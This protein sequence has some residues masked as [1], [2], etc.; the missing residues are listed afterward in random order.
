MRAVI[1]LCWMILGT[2]STIAQPSQTVF[3]ETVNATTVRFFFDENYFLVDKDC[4]F[5]SVERV[6]GFDVT[7]SQLDGRFTDFDQQGNVILEGNYRNGRKEGLFQAYHPNGVKKWETRFLNNLPVGLWEYYYPDG[8]PMLTL[9]VDSTQTQIL[10]Y[11][12]RRGR[13]RVKNGSGLYDFKIPMQG[14][15]PYG[16]SFLRYRG[17]LK[18]GKPNGYWE[19]F[20]QSEDQQSERVAEE[21]YKNGRLQ[22]GMDLIQQAPYRS[23]RYNFLPFESFVRG[24]TLI[25]KQCS[26]DD[27]SGFTLYLANHLTT[28]FAQATTPPANEQ[29]FELVFQVS[30]AGETSS[31]LTTKS[32]NEEMDQAILLVLQ[33]VDYFVP[34]VK[35]DVLIDDKITLSG[36]VSADERGQLEFHSLSIGRENGS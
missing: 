3:L 33:S 9:E 34:S 2:L 8:R 21:E 36:V 29:T 15:N 1:L 12:D 30:V 14:Y 26:Y 19:I 4:V 28:A 16:Y 35:N 20:F 18:D 32:I 17:R 25:S 5:K 11:T 13:P 7:S 23:L 31:W 27:F 22:S 24:E 6:A 10:S